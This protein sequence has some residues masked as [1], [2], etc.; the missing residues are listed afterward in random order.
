MPNK[1]AA[2]EPVPP[3]AIVHT[4]ARVMYSRNGNREYRIFVFKPAHEAPPEGFPVIYVLDANAVF[5]TMAEA[6]RLQSRKPHGFGPA[7]IVGI[8]YPTEEPLDSTRRF[9]D[10]TKPASAKLPVRP[11]GSPWS[12]T[13]GADAFLSFIEDELKPA[14]ER[15]FPI[16]RNRQTLF[17]HSLGGL[18]T[19]DVWLNRPETFQTYVAG[20]PS[21]WWNNRYLLDAARRLAE[22]QKD[23]ALPAAV[24]MAVGGKEKPF[25]IQ[26]ARE[27]FQTVE[28][29]SGRGIRLQFMELEDEGHITI[30][31]PLINRALRFALAES[32]EPGGRL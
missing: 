6:V 4:E 19:L 32:G 11:D 27:L 17:G 14:I 18:F 2:L 10:Y 5:G 9:Y 16:D 25:M 30:L 21:I 22:R 7:V 28:P 13:G 1:K 31:L 23:K 8:G 29:L 3:Y 26:D 24:L 20:S 15:D 12:E